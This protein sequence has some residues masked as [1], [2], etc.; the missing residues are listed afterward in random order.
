MKKENKKRLLCV[1]LV[2]AALIAGGGLY[3]HIGLPMIMEPV[4]ED[5]VLSVGVRQGYGKEDDIVLTPDDADFHWFVNYAANLRMLFPV[6]WKPISFGGSIH[7]GF[8]LH[9][10]NGN[11]YLFWD[12][13]ATPLLGFELPTVKVNDVPYIIH[14]TPRRELRQILN[15]YL[16][17]IT[18]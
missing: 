6:K 1:L 14:E 18:N 5:T 15:K 9:M 8:V 17:M 4:N 7:T 12:A 13:S 11:D 16:K 3:L 2:I 10:K